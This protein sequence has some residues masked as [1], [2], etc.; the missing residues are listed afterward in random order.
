LPKR[1][2]CDNVWVLGGIAVRLL[3]ATQNLGKM[4]EFERLLSPLGAEL[5]FPSDLGLE[6]EVLEDGATYV[7]NARKKAEAF[8]RA[9]DL[10]TLADDSG[11]EVDALYGAP[12]V[13]SARYTEGHDGDRI[14]ALLTQLLEVPWEQRTAR[15]RCVIVI[16]TP[17]GESY[18]TEGICEGRIALEPVGEG[19]FGYDPVFYLVRYGCTM[20]Q[21]PQEEKNRISHRGRAA[22]AAL[23]ILSRLMVE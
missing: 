22:E 9:S 20:A 12:G 10:L 15:F 13:R 7:D 5:C 3:I 11:L 17:E 19:G 16:I 21:L 14:T 6:L 23:R 18:T 2:V 1:L 8:V 4:R